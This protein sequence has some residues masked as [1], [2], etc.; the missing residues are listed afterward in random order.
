PADF[1]LVGSAGPVAHDATPPDSLSQR[2]VGGWIVL[3]YGDCTVAI[4]PLKCRVLD[5]PDDDPNP[6]RRLQGNVVD[7]PVRV[8]REDEALYLSLPLIEGAHGVITQPLLYSGW[9]V[10]VLDS[11]E[12]VAGLRVTETLREDGE[13][14]RTYGELIREVELTTP[15]GTI[16]LVR[17][18]LTG[19]EWR[20]TDG[21][22][23]EK[24]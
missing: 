13:I 21:E 22:A 15:R 9:C 19:E 20:W 10:V 17:D 1:T 24:A 8:E 12:E 23:R 18:M 16:K 14:P 4:R 5:A 11:A 3:D 6:Q 7:L 2:T